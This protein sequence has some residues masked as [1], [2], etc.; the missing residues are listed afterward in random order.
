MSVMSLGRL[1]AKGLSKAFD[2]SVVA[3]L[4]DL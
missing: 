4:T 2:N 1:S 3:M